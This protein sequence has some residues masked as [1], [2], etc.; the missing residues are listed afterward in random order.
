MGDKAI[1]EISA[2]LHRLAKPKSTPK[3]LL[4]AV[5]K[6]HPDATKKAIVRAAFYSIIANADAAR[7]PA[8]SLHVAKSRGLRASSK[9]TT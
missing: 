7:K 3:E 1:E 9:Q 2:T 4:K 8:F 5:R 6:H